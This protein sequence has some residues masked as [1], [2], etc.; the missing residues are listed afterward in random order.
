M[1]TAT[2]RSPEVGADYIDTL[3]RFHYGEPAAAQATRRPEGAV[4]PA[5]LNPYRDAATI[6]YRYPL[7][8][9][10][11]D[12]PD[13]APLATPLAQHLA[14]SIE[15][16]APGDDE[17]RILKDN[18]PWLERHLRNALTAPDPVAAPASFEAAAAALEEHLDLGQSN[19]DTLRSD[20]ESLRAAIA[21]GSEFL[22]YGPDAPL[23]LLL[24]AIRRHG[25]PRR[26]ALRKRIA[27]SK[28]VLESLLKVE[29]ARSGPAASG[30]AAERLDASLLS[31][32]LDKR[33][34]GSVAMSAERR[35]RIEQ[36][37]GVLQAWD[38]D[39][40]LV[41][42]IGKVK[43]PWFG[44]EDTVDV[45]D[46][47]DPCAAAGETF[48]RDALR[49]A[50]L[51]AALRTAAL[52]KEDSYD[53]AVHDSWFAGFDWQSF[54]ADELRHVT[55]VVAI[56]SADHLAGDG[57]PSFSRLLGSRRP[58]HIVSWIRAYDNPAVQPG[59]GPFDAYRFELAYFGVG[60]RQ[61]IVAQTSAASHD[62]MLA[63]F[64]CALDSNR[65]SLHLINRGTQTKSEQ[66]I[67]DPWF[68][69]S[70]A[71]ESRA[72][73]LLLVN[74]DAGD[75]AAERVSFA[76]NPQA[77][78]DWP[79]ESLEYEDPDGE[80]KEMS[81]AFTFADYA[82]LMPALHEH[83]RMVPK[84]YES[85]D[86]VPV[87]NYLDSDSEAAERLVPF[88]W[89][90]DED[91]SLVRLAVSRALIFAC[92]DRLNYWHTLQELA[93]VHNFYVEE[94]VERVL[95]DAR[96]AAE[97]EREELLKAHAEELDSARSAAA[98]EAMGQLVDVLMGADLSSMIGDSAPATMPAA[99]TTDAVADDE[100][101]VDE[102]EAEPE[103]EPDPEEE[104]LSFDEPW[105]DTAACTTCDDCISINKMMFAY[106]A[107]K[108]AI[109]KDPRAGTYAELVQAAETCPAKCIHPGK[110]LD[111][112][113]PGLDELMARAAPFN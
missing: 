27:D 60:H 93:G 95:E 68:V 110:P 106:N 24:H 29:A 18:L 98:G 19:R 81:L 53:P 96:A 78:K 59:E 37:L 61:A 21:E 14:Q 64:E 25:L 80:R 85:D 44:R 9:A 56:V 105:L 67:L 54:S 22:G 15:T 69:A 16:F 42:F 107:D 31:S 76:G 39:P 57:L 7:Y 65:T 32:M 90:I 66:P 5:L 36:A 75:Y 46:S 48:E 103:P 97:A 34:H 12:A 38:D 6:R 88:V 58:V 52:E 13:E 55:P 108:Q 28:R 2:D 109:L 50:G 99:E 45:I 101:V 3:R 23:H 33:S 30:A 4:L 51:F 113:E 92:R 40:V 94:A 20:L 47:T 26:E 84:G 1:S 62:D 63:G 70:A 35:A 49:F 74:P 77:D 111:P 100:P 83:F 86:L 43:N 71:V 17:A 87:A 89:A 112:N 104:E 91:G 10:P 102:A 82:L 41:R 11:Y 79:V 72:H 8:L 73:P